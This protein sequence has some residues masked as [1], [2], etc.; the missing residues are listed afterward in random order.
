M[1]LTDALKTD[2]VYKKYKSIVS[3]VGGEFDKERIVKDAKALHLSRKSRDFRGITPTAQQVYHAQIGD[4][5][6]RGKLTDLRSNIHQHRDL[7]S[8]SIDTT[9]TYIIAQYLR[10]REG[11][12]IGDRKAI[13]D[14]FLASGITLLSELDSVS[15]LLE[16]YVSDIDRAGYGF[17]NL[18]ALL[19]ILGPNTSTASM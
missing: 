12:R 3:F 15:T 4:M 2:P 11:V 13:A 8:T 16:M 17:T 7:L 19:R 9:R 10:Q 14:R 18:V 5:N 6:A 1:K